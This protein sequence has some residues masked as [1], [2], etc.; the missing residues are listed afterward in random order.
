MGSVSA[1]AMSRRSAEC[2]LGGDGLIFD[3]VS[4]DL[5]GAAVKGLRAHDRTDE[6]GLSRAVVA[7]EAVDAA[8]LD[9]E[10]EV[11]HRNVVAIA[12]LKIANGKN[13]HER[14]QKTIR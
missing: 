3:A 6:R 2:A 8:R 1:S 5:D 7:D 9:S 4:A 13:R 10:G 11:A 14:L 12:F